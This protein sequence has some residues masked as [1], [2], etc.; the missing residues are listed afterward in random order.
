VG[1]E[2]V[3]SRVTE[4]VKAAVLDFV[5]E[6]FRGEKLV[7]GVDKGDGEVGVDE[8]EFGGHFNAHGS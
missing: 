3:D 1:Y 5:G 8:F 2:H 7:V 6:G 4:E